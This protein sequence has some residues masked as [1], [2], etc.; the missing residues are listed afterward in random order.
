[1]HT[2]ANIRAAFDGRIATTENPSDAGKL[3]ARKVLFGGHSR[4]SIAPVFSRFGGVNWFVWDIE[5]V[6]EITGAPG[7]VVRIASTIGEA[8]AG[9]DLNG[10]GLASFEI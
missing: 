8:L 3:A 1:M 9:L 4:Y 5:G 7:E 6:D 2:I 10:D